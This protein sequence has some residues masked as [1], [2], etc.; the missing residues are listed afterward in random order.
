MRKLQ[1][2]DV[3][4]CARTAPWGGVVVF[5]NGDALNEA[6]AVRPESD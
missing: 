6:A 1:E 5:M 3:I 2:D 4:N